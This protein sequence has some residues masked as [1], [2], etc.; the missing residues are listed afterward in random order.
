MTEA[1]GGGV[2]S[3]KEKP[4]SDAKAPEKRKQYIYLYFIYLRS[5]QEEGSR[6]NAVRGQGGGISMVHQCGL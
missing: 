2:G 3:E 1:G 4:Y 6:N 5:A